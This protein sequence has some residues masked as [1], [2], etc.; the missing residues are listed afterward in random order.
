MTR[1]WSGPVMAGPATG[2]PAT[3]GPAIGGPAAGMGPVGG[4][5]GAP[6]RRRPGGTLRF[7]AG[8]T[9]RARGILIMNWQPGPALRTAI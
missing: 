9:G 6:A 4:P 2:G 5:V 7:M 1:G 3:G 8:T